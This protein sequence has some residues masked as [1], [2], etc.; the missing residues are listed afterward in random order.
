MISDFTTNLCAV[1]SDIINMSC[2]EDTL[3]SSR[4]RTRY[5]LYNN[6]TSLNN[7]GYAALR[8]LASC[9]TASRMLAISCMPSIATRHSS[10]YCFICSS[11]Y[12]RQTRAIGPKY[13]NLR[14]TSSVS[15]DKAR[16]LHAIGQSINNRHI[17]DTHTHSTSSH[18][19]GF[20]RAR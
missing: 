2:S 7:V 19:Q 12:S 16:A 10:S 18:D 9:M 3:S 8:S 6:L 4:C 1:K 20:I 13:S 17:S 14:R 11:S 15:R 5:T